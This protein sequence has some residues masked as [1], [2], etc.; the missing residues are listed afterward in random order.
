MI[1]L[2]SYQQAVVDQVRQKYAAG[3][4]A[5]MV[6]MPTGAGKTTVFSYV[7][8]NAAAKSRCVY[9][10]CHRA[11]LVKQITMTLA[12]FGCAH[13]V[14]APP[15]I[16]RQCQ[17]EQHRRLGKSWVNHRARVFVAS[18][19]TL[20]KRLASLPAEHHPDL[21]I[22]DEA[23]HLTRNSTWGKIVDAFP[24]AKLLPVTA[25]PCRLDGKGLGVDSGGFADCMVLG[26]SMRE[27]IDAG[28]LSPY[29]IFAPPTALDLSK[30]K[31][32][33]GDY[34]KDQLAE[35]T[36]KPTI[37]GDAVDH[38]RRLAAGK[39]AVAFCVSVEHARHV[40]EQFLASGI[41]AEMLDGSADPAERDACIKRFERG[42]T[43]VLTS[44]EIVS[45]GFD[46]PAIE[47]AILL[48]ATKSVSLFLQQVGRALR[49][50]P[51]KD[52]AL[53][54]DHVGAIRQHGFPDDERDWTL[55]GVTKK[56]RAA[57]DN[58]PNVA[59]QTCPKCFSVHR[60]APVCPTCSHVYTAKERKLEVAE[61]QLQ[62]ITPEQRAAMRVMA[63]RQKAM[64]QRQRKTEE[65]QCKTLEDFI[66]LGESR[67]YK[68]A[69][70]WAE[71]RFAFRQ[72][73]RA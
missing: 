65:S 49:V 2:R 14:I 26:P 71:K 66:A 10:L 45:E 46:L 70:A 56:K 18:A 42:E 64:Q 1:A 50:F 29:R 43:L 17:V 20:V 72:Q 19:Q 58:E 47:V 51:G 15:A 13:Q 48:R 67:G 5:P 35:A 68:F 38:Y 63:E 6:V 57:N 44:C 4:R 28:F 30:V 53:I 11:E 16:G 54:F 69:R 22:I 3:F 21:I 25:T 33:A 37:T 36:D 8:T 12:S 52:E 7:T 62:E 55:D 34:A 41:P 73:R 9:L 27:L 40:A 24:K 32:R 23:H 60:P 61:G 31:T 59:I 39:R